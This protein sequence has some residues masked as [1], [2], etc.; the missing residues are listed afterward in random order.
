MSCFHLHIYVHVQGLSFIAAQNTAV[1]AHKTRASAGTGSESCGALDS[2]ERNE[3]YN[4][5][6]RLSLCLSE[7]CYHIERY[8]TTGVC[9]V[10]KS[11]FINFMF[12]VPCI[13]DLH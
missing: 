2:Y 7:N 4:K 10:H 1:L 3:L 12:M 11:E 8:D 5:S 9:T 13:A 6:A